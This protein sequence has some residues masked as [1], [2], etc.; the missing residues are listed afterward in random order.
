[1]RVEPGSAA[2]SID[3]VVWSRTGHAVDWGRCWY[4]PKYFR[5]SVRRRRQLGERSVGEGFLSPMTPK[6]PRAT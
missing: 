3:T 6:T 2:L 1:L 4:L 5:F